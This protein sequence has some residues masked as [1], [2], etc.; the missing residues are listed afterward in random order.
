M[1]QL[2]VWAIFEI[3]L[4][5]SITCQDVKGSI[6]LLLSIN[7]LCSLTKCWW[8]PISKFVDDDRPLADDVEKQLIFALRC[9]KIAH[10]WICCWSPTG[11]FVDAHL[12]MK[13]LTGCFTDVVETFSLTTTIN[14]ID[15][16]PP[17]L[18]ERRDNL[19]Q[20]IFE[21][22]PFRCRNVSLVYSPIQ[23]H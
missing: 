18:A 2:K 22:P 16:F 6:Y 17:F 3:L 12:L 23:L 21:L 1:S 8:M 19:L 20:I 5:N 10:C 7:I 11:E 4:D 14:F 15:I 9:F 13:M